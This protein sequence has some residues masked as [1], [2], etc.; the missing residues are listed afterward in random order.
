[1]NAPDRLDDW[2]NAGLY[3]P[4]ADDAD[5]RIELLTWLDAGGIGLADMVAAELAGQLSAV[6]GDRSPF[7]G[8]N[9]PASDRST[10]RDAD[11]VRTPVAA[12]CGHG[13]RIG[14]G[15]RNRP[16]QLCRR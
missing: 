3:D 16:P 11:R 7:L 14:G 12:R 5:Q 4:N 15:R 10:R 9:L 2:I 6:A 13:P 8:A 1:M